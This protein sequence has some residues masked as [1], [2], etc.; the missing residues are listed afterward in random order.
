MKSTTIVQ[1]NAM[2]WPLA[3]GMLFGSGCANQ[4]ELVRPTQKNVGHA[5]GESASCTPELLQASNGAQRFIVEWNDGD[6]EALETEMAN[7]V[8][9]VKYTCEGIEVLRSCA[10]PGEYGYRPSSSQKTKTLQITDA[11]SA[12][13]NLSS[14]TPGAAIQAAMDQGKALN[15]AY[16]MIG[17]MNTPVKDVSR[18]QLNRAACK[19]GTHFVY[20]TQVGA[21]AI[22][23]GEQGKAVAAASVLGYGNAEGEVS[24]ERQSL[25]ADGDARRCE[26]ASPSDTAPPAGCSALMRVSIIPLIDGKAEAAKTGGEGGEKARVT[27][28][29][30]S[31]PQGMVFEDDLCVKASETK[32]FLCKRGD[33]S[34][35]ETQC[36]NGSNESC[37][38]MAEAFLEQN[39]FYSYY[40]KSEEKSP[41]EFKALKNSKP[42][43]PL[44]TKACED[45]E[46]ANACTLAGLIVGAQTG[47]SNRPSNEQQAEQ[48]LELLVPGCALGNSIACDFV[49]DALGFEYFEEFGIA[50]YGKEMEEV[51]GHGCDS[52]ASEACMA[53]GG[54]FYEG[55]K[56]SDDS[57]LQ[58][59]IKKAAKYTAKACLSGVS[60]A[61]FWSAAMYATNNQ[62]DCVELIDEVA[63]EDDEEVAAHISISFP[64]L[65]GEKREEGVKNFCRLSAKIYDASRAHELANKACY[66]SGGDLTSHA[67]EMAELLED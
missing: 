62:A 16:V 5:L 29:T 30:R 31:C 1:K 55:N 61:C 40:R 67:C 9:V 7:G 65:N 58:S 51:I 38:R 22:E 50:G 64:D 2:I 10:V 37:G 18:D 63:P 60:E 24:S 25:S 26:A 52:G 48:M 43:L 66:L 46:E 3:L 45:A 54:F 47:D 4:A 35:C 28:D 6:R 17:S 15:L 19:E 27:I 32:S 20:Q 33:L 14:P 53:L 21:F 23:A 41:K 11:A 56:Y 34:G 49:L 8:A 39:K 42:L 36:K 59:D 57:A 44:L 12:S 13:A